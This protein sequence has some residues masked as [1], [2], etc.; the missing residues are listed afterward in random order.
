MSN[1]F[2][3]TEGFYTLDYTIL[4]EIGT[5]DNKGF[6]YIT[7]SGEIV[8]SSFSVDCLMYP[9]GSYT[10]PELVSILDQAHLKNG[11]VV[12]IRDKDAYYDE[13]PGDD[14]TELNIPLSLA[15]KH[16]NTMFQ[17]SYVLRYTGTNGAFP[18]TYILN[19]E[20]F[21]TKVSDPFVGNFTGAGHI[22]TYFKP[23]PGSSTDAL[24][25]INIK[26][27]IALVN[28]TVLQ[29]KYKIKITSEDGTVFYNLDGT[30]KT[31]PDK[32][33]LIDNDNIDISLL[34]SK[35]PVQSTDPNLLGTATIINYVIY[36]SYIGQDGY[37]SKYLK[38]NT[39]EFTDVNTG[40]DT[41]NDVVITD[42]VIDD[43]KSFLIDSDIS[44]KKRLCLDVND[45]K[46]DT[47]TYE[48]SGEYVSEYYTINKPL[49][50]V[51]LDVTEFYGANKEGESFIP[52]CIRYYIQFENME[53]VRISPTNRDNEFINVKLDDNSNS[54]VKKIIPKMLVLDDLFIKNIN[55]NI[56]S[57]DTGISIYAFRI[58]IA[59]DVLVN[60]NISVN[61]DDS[62]IAPHVSYYG[63]NI[64]DKDSYLRK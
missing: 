38:L 52:D 39:K 59:I 50:T 37:E 63:L 58:I 21:L 27:D 57:V 42:L 9:E 17:C 46:L 28:E 6:P 8:P 47:D 29:T 36:L 44:T 7:M 15:K 4:S 13:F 2:I 5:T 49:Y 33:T 54:T 64:T 43:D 45:I 53:R 19:D 14:I 56:V 55:S 1:L 62:F 22:E 20:L 34:Y 40:I 41:A 31:D 48:T 12:E 51:S 30:V 24:I 11:D 23:K 32:F 18:N 25:D 3:N 10:D 16:E 35:T 60:D 61:V 26:H